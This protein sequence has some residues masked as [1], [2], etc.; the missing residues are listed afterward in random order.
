MNLLPIAVM[1]AA[2]CQ[3]AM[4]CIPSR[5]IPESR[6][7]EVTVAGPAGPL[8]GTMV[9]DPGAP[10]VLL[11]PGSGPTDR[12]GDNPLGV[13]GA[14]YRQL[15]EALRQRGIGSL[16]ADKRGIGGSATPGKDANAV[17]IADYAADAAA[18]RDLLIANGHRCVWLAGHSEGGLIALAL[19]ARDPSSLCG[20]IL[21]AA[22]GRPV[23]VALR[24]QLKPKLPA[25][26]FVAADAAIARLEKGEP[27]DPASVPAPI[28]PLF[29][30]AVQGFLGDMLRHDPDKLARATK[31]P[32]L[33]VKGETDIQVSLADAKA[34]AAARPDARLVLVPGVNHVWKK[35]PRDPAANAATYADAELKIDQAVVDAIAAFVLD[36]R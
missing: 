10:V 20:L 15:A 5:A 12:N 24:E 1:A 36:K 8:A 19:A 14:I 6:V 23:G 30:P 2:L 22:P 11:L 21:L 33:I 9:S 35:A 18:L 26:M 3:P 28:A 29:H 7:S 25:D 31:L 17:T 34:L 13:K 27:V 16:R 4:P 32:M